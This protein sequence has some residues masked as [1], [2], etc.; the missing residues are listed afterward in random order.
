MRLLA[1]HVDTE[2]LLQAVERDPDGRIAAQEVLLRI[3]QERVAATSTTEFAPRVMQNARRSRWWLPA[4]AAAV[5][6]IA[7][8][9]MFHFSKKSPP[10][11]EVAFAVDGPTSERQATVAVAVLK[12]SVGV[13]WA[14]N[15]PRMRSGRCSRRDGCG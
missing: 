9:L 7:A 3:E 4:S 2:R 1:N 15:S 13:Q 10:A 6:A 5:L 8:G 14:E 11:S 12:R